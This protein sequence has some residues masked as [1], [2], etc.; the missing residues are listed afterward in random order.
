[1]EV[2][3]KQTKNWEKY[4][5]LLPCKE[6][7]RSSRVRVID[8]TQ[9]LVYWIEENAREMKDLRKLLKSYTP[10]ISPTESVQDHVENRISRPKKV[11]LPVIQLLGH[12][13]PGGLAWV[14]KVQTAGLFGHGLIRNQNQNPTITSTAVLV[15]RKFKLNI[16]TS[17][18]RAYLTP[19]V[20]LGN[21]APELYN[22]TP[23]LSPREALP[24]IWTQTA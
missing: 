8:P 18:C 17:D 20:Q 5:C 24:G 13:D 6:E 16:H 21:T 7:E 22:A 14:P 19:L 11:Y 4:I 15:Y 10:I 3:G 12:E 1:M 9:Y 23:R 2:H